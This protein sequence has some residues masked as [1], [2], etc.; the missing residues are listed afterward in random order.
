MRRSSTI[1]A[2]SSRAACKSSTIS[3][4]INSGG[5]TINEEK[6]IGL[7]KAMPRGEFANGNAA[8]GID[9]RIGAVFDEPSGRHKHAIYALAG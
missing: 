7:T 9:V 3:A 5:L 4:A 8:A 2:N 6:V 1:K